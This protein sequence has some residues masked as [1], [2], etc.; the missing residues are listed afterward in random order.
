MS[1]MSIQE[2]AEDMDRIAKEMGQSLL[3]HFKTVYGDDVV[4]RAAAR[5]AEK[6]DD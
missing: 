2:I 6:S 1:E 5:A 4:E 3:D